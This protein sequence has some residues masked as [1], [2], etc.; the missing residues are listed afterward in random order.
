[1]RRTQKIS[2]RRAEPR[3]AEGIHATFCAPLAMAGTLQLP[4]PS[5]E[6][7]RKRMAEFPAEDF[8]LVATVGDDIVGN[9]ALHAAS[10]SPRRRHAGLIGI[11]VRDDWHNRSVGSAL[12][13]AELDLADNWLNLTRLELTVYTDNVAALALYGKFGFVI[14]GTHRNFA[15]ATAS[16]SMPMQWPGL[17]TVEVPEHGVKPKRP[18]RKPR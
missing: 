6:M 1:M 13:I 18:R 5:A 2:V 17:K 12:L 11:A 9:V 4:F 8:F 15:F 16:T 10:K 7:W 14:E 3:D